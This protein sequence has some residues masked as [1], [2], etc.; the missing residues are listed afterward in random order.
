[1]IDRL[2]N[3]MGK[4][5]QVTVFIIVG[6]MIVM[7][8]SLIVFTDRDVGL[9]S[10]LR[11]IQADPV[12]DYVEECVEEVLDLSLGFLQ[13]NAGYF[14]RQGDFNI[15]G[16][17]YLDASSYAMNSELEIQIEYEIE[18]K[19]VSDC[20]L[21]VFD[22]QYDTI[23]EGEIEVN[24][25]IDRHVVSAF[26]IY[27]ITLAKD[28]SIVDLGSFFISRDDEFGILNSVAGK[29]INDDL[30]LDG[31][32]EG[33]DLDGWNSG[34]RGIYDGEFILVERENS[35]DFGTRYIVESPFETE[36]YAFLVR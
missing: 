17:S 22:R 20:D 19:L 5:G 31:D 21:G 9:D 8:A 16:L 15:F 24:V 23:D 7:I 1:M 34:E 32:G 11:G 36:V 13:Q 2:K 27:P 30:D 10:S 35:V 33:F 12:R 28:N 14:T 29:I 26:V 25:D 4:R 18:N 6:V 3:R